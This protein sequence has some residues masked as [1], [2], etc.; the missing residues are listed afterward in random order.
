MVG[1]WVREPGVW[2]FFLGGGGVLACPFWRG[3]LSFL[4][5]FPAG[6]FWH[7]SLLVL[8]SL[9][10]CVSFLAWFLTGSYWPGSLL[11]LLAWFLAGPFCH[12]ALLV[13]FGIAPVCPFGHGYGLSFLAWL[14]ACFHRRSRS[15]ACLNAEVS[16]ERY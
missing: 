15:F 9:V 2:S 12:G 16:P 11:V 4:A 6:P 14:L 8:F 7:G 10:P 3:S 1:A 5:W 13:L